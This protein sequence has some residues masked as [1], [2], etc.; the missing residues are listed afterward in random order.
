M[1]RTITPYAILKEHFDDLLNITIRG[2]SNFGYVYEDLRDAYDQMFDMRINR[3]EI[4]RTALK[5]PSLPIGAIATLVEPED[6]EKDLETGLMPTERAVVSVNNVNE[7]LLSAIAHKR[8]NKDQIREYSLFVY[9]AMKNV[10]EWDVFYSN[11]YK[12]RSNPYVLTVKILPFYFA[13]K[14]VSEWCCSKDDDLKV[15]KQAF[16]DIIER[17]VSPMEEYVERILDN[18]IERPFT[19]SIHEIYRI[20]TLKGECDL[21]LLRNTL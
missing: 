9:Q 16:R 5:I 20:V 19:M 18:I 2:F 4:H 17:D 12:A 6:Y 10:V 3:V 7:T 8:A 15:V 21:F 11:D 14:H 1:M 13:L